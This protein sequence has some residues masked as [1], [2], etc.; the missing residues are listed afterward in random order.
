MKD[1]EAAEACVFYACI[2]SST[3]DYVDAMLMS[4]VRSKKLAMMA[5]MIKK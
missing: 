5:T 3:C 2:P 1:A 4:I